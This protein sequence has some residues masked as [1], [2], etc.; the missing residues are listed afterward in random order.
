MIKGGG[1]RRAKLNLTRRSDCL[2]PSRSPEITAESWPF[3]E[4]HKTSPVPFTVVVAMADPNNI[5]Q[6]LWPPAS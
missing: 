3:T 5:P 2:V 4:Q 6:L 1:E